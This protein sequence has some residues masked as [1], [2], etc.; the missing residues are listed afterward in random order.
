MMMLKKKNEKTV[1]LHTFLLT[2]EQVTQLKLQN[3]HYVLLIPK[4]FVTTSDPTFDLV[5]QNNRLSLI[6]PKI[7]RVTATP[8]GAAT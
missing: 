1:T 3:Q 4:K 6:G 8:P 5:I 7:P 2:K